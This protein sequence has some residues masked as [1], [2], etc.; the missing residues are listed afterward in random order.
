[1]AEKCEVAVQRSHFRVSSLLPRS[2]GLVC[3]GPGEG[4]AARGMASIVAPKAAKAMRRRL[5]RRAPR[6]NE[7]ELQRVLMARVGSSKDWQKC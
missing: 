4:A 3:A 2:A 7:V 1:M 5:R 6:P